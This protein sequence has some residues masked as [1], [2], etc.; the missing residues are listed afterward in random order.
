MGALLHVNVF[1]TGLKSFIETA[2]DNKIAIYGTVLEGEP[3]YSHKLTNRGVILFG[4][5]SRGISDDLMPLVTNKISIPGVGQGIP[6]IESL[7]V[8]MA[9]SVIFSEFQRQTRSLLNF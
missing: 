4:N 2:I 8:S 6:G 7:N 9:A 3:V 1:Y 5:E